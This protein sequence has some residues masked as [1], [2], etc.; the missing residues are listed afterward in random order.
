MVQNIAN[1]NGVKISV[2]EVKFQKIMSG[3]LFR[4]KLFEQ[5]FI[6]QLSNIKNDSNQL[7]FSRFGTYVLYPQLSSAKSKV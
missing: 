2:S 7:I 4:K 6:P 5:A 3:S 1:V